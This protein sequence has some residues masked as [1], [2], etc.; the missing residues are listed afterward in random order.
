MQSNFYRRFLGGA[1][2]AAIAVPAFAQNAEAPSPQ[3]NAVSPE[4]ESSSGYVTLDTLRLTGSRSALEEAQ[5][6]LD[7]RAGGTS[8]VGAD[9]FEDSRATTLSDIL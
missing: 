5:D 1:A 2:V 8:V 3:I 7:L 9:A 4:A 6:E